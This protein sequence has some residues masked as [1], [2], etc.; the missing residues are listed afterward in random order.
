MRMN[1]MIYPLNFSIAMIQRRCPKIRRKI[2]LT[3]FPL[4][5]ILG[6]NLLLVGVT[7]NT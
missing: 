2:D 1:L 5:T 7:Q 6:S 3:I 4:M